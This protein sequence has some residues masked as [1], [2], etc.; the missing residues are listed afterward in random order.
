MYNTSLGEITIASKDD[1]IVMVKL[2]CSEFIQKD[3]TLSRFSSAT[4]PAP[5]FS[6]SKLTDKAAKQLEEY[7]L[8]KR[9][10]FDLKLCLKGTVFQQSVWNALKTIPYGET[11]S[12]KQIAEQIGNPKAVRAVGM[13]NNKNPIWIIIPCHRVIGSS[14]SLVG[15]GGGLNIK[16]KLLLLEN[17][18]YEVKS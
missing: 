9:R 6:P 16:E 1:A 13:A 7:L 17:P 12:Y 5:S 11:R 15:Y 2:G 4:E 18:Q 3:S 10:E 8:G 14:G